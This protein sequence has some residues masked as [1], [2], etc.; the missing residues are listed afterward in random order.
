[1]DVTV[2]GSGPNGLTAAVICAR[3]GL[4]VQVI[5]A[6]QTFGG[7]SRTAADFEFPESCT[8]CA[9]RCT[10]W[11]W[12]RRF[13]RVRSGLPGVRLAVPHISYANPLPDRPAAIA[14]RDLRQTCAELEH[15]PSW[16]RLLSRS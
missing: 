7:G 2:V 8:T 3:A 6:Q 16:E 15:G 11:R 1:M 10:H 5:E 9:Q 14:Y 4:R 13:L 12:R